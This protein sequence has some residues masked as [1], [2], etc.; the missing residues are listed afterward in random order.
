MSKRLHIAVMLEKT[1]Y[2]VNVGM[3]GDNGSAHQLIFEA[4]AGSREDPD[5][6]N[7]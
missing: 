3:A 7:A 4:K 1:G 2:F 5:I 6:S